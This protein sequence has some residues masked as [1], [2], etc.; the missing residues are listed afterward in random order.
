M[1][2]PSV[3][4]SRVAVV[5]ALAIPP[6]WAASARA[7]PAP[8]ASPAV[9]PACSLWV[10]TTGTQLLYRDFYS[11]SLTYDPKKWPLLM[12]HAKAARAVFVDPRLADAL[13]RYDALVRSLGVIGKRLISGD[14]SSA[15]RALKSAQPDLRATVAAV[16]K[17][18]VVCKSGST[19]LHFD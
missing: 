1:F 8:S 13:P 6:A 16:R 4:A 19:V 11:P 3:T 15:Y 2:T 7:T 5:I 10:L 18:D 14:R 9:S 17:A 12:A